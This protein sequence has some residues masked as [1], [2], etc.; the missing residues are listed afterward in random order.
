MAV[1]KTRMKSRKGAIFDSLVIT[2][3]KHY[4]VKFATYSEVALVG[5]S[6][7]TIQEQ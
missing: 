2:V 4:I 7:T 6:S 5:I 1:Y 3:N